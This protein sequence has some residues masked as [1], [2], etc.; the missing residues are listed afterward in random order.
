AGGALLELSRL[1][2]SIDGYGGE[3]LRGVQDEHRLVADE[4]LSVGRGPGGRR[5]EHEEKRRDDCSA[6][7]AGA[8]SS[9]ASSPPGPPGASSPSDTP[10]GC[11]GPPR[12]R[13]RRRRGA[14]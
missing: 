8:T 6:A 12:R 13:W 14:S 9:C 7:H 2:E 10:C 5:R 1:Q 4:Q 11:P 3:A